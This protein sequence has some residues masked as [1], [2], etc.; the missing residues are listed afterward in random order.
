MSLFLIH[1]PLWIRINLATRLSLLNYLII[2]KKLSFVFLKIV[3][4]YLHP[5]S[6]FLGIKGLKLQTMLKILQQSVE[7]GG[8][9]RQLMMLCSLALG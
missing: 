2:N 3:S 1:I 9:G 6:L 5:K 7:K 8:Y 4:N